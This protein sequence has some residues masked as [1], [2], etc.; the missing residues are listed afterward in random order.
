MR[1]EVIGIGWVTAEGLGRGRQ[2][3]SFSLK[4]GALP[5]VSRKD[6]F[7]DPYQRFG[8]LDEFSRIGLAAIAFALRDAGVEEWQRKRLHALIAGTLYGCLSTDIDYFATALSDGGQLA[9]PNLFA[10][11]LPNCFLGEA[12]IRFGLTGPGY[13]VS[14]RETGGLTA[15]RL[16]VETIAWDEAETAVAGICDLPRSAVLESS[17]PERPGAVFLVLRR[18]GTGEGEP[19]G[20]VGVD[21]AGELMVSGRKVAGLE[22]LVQELRK[23]I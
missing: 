20:E 23:G 7:A 6:V 21:A 14:E 16:G 18:C 19:L 22:H 12:A 3:G 10:Y 11:T 9:S 17:G 8:R 13:V 2:P 15:L 5:P 1:A 4:A